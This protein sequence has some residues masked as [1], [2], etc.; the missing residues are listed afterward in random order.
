MLYIIK[1]MKYEITKDIFRGLYVYIKLLTI[2]N[3]VNRCS[4]MRYTTCTFITWLNANH[5]NKNRY[6]HIV[7][8]IRFDIFLW[9]MLYYLMFDM[10][11]N[12]A[13][14]CKRHFG[15]YLVLAPQ[16]Y[17]IVCNFEYFTVFT[18]LRLNNYVNNYVP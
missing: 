16:K 5:S 13:C 8:S 11:P 10:F 15:I 18:V 2:K 1:A 3:D 9:I 6:L 12:N 4:E 7:I 17:K 14:K